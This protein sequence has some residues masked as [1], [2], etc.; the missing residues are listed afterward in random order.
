[1]KAELK[2][3]AVMYFSQCFSITQHC[4]LSNF[5]KISLKFDCRKKNSLAVPFS[6][7]FRSLFTN[8]S[9]S[10]LF[11]SLPVKFQLKPSLSMKSALWFI[12]NPIPP[13]F[14]PPQTHLIPPTVSCCKCNKPLSPQRLQ[15][16]F[17]IEIKIVI[18]DYHQSLN[19]PLAARIANTKA[20]FYHRRDYIEAITLVADESKAGYRNVYTLLLPSTADR[21]REGKNSSSPHST[22]STLNRM[23]RETNLKVPIGVSCVYNKTWYVSRFFRAG[24]LNLTCALCLWKLNDF[25]VVGA[26][27]VFLSSLTHS[28][29]CVHHHDSISMFIIAV[30]FAVPCAIVVERARFCIFFGDP[31]STRLRNFYGSEF[32]VMNAVAVW[33]DL[34]GTI[35]CLTLA[36][37]HPERVHSLAAALLFLIG[38]DKILIELYCLLSGGCIRNHK[39]QPCLAPPERSTL[40]FAHPCRRRNWKRL[41]RSNRCLFFLFAYVSFEHSAMAAVLS[42]VCFDSFAYNVPLQTSLICG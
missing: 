8:I 10:L 1:M 42:R 29:S 24:S 11:N 38:D 15:A 36:H 37:W 21:M 20:S 27:N 2:K 40:A 39:V 5:S 41:H 22:R 16:H 19:A 23:R 32:S 33:G 35:V 6:S 14:W 30:D 7:F 34:K 25:V 13:T 31:A 3:S 17:R 9:S 4:F 12:S 28:Y 26:R 18:S